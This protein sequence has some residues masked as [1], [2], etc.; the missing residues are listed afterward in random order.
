M[1]GLKRRSPKKNWSK[2]FVDKIETAQ[3]EKRE[4]EVIEEDD[5]AG[6]KNLSIASMFIQDMVESRAINVMKAKVNALKSK[7]TLQTLAPPKQHANWNASWGSQLLCHICGLPGIS[8]TVICQKCDNIAHKQCIEFSLLDKGITRITYATFAG[9][10]CDSCSES[11]QVENDWYTR[12]KKELQ[13]EDRTDTAARRIAKRCLI[14]MERKRLAEKKAAVIKL[15]AAARM[16]VQLKKYLF[17]K[18]AQMRLVTIDVTRFPPP[19]IENGVVVLTLFDTY[20]NIQS[21]RLDK[22]IEE[23]LREKFLIPGLTAN[24]TVVLTLAKEVDLH[25]GSKRYF[26]YAQAELNLRDMRHFDRANTYSLNFVEKIKWPPQEFKGEFRFHM[27]PL[28]LLTSAGGNIASSITNISNISIQTAAAANAMNNPMTMQSG[29]VA[30]VSAFKEAQ[31]AAQLA[32]EAAGFLETTSIENGENNNGD[33]MSEARSVY[34]SVSS[35]RS[36]KSAAAAR[37][38]Q[39]FSHSLSKSMSTESNSGK[40]FSEHDK[41][42]ATA[43]ADTST[44][45]K[46]AVAA[47]RSGAAGRNGGTNSNNDGGNSIIPHG[48]ASQDYAGDS[49]QEEGGNLDD[50][51]VSSDGSLHQQY[52]QQ[53]QEQEQH[54]NAAEGQSVALGPGM[55]V[56]S[57]VT[58]NSQQS[59]EQQSVFRT[60]IT[61]DRQCVLHYHPQNPTSTMVKMVFGPPLDILK[62]AADSTFKGTKAANLANSSLSRNSRYWLCLFQ[63]KL[64]LFQYFGDVSPRF[65]ADVSEATAS[66]V[67]NNKGKKTAVVSILHADAQRQ[68]L[69]EFNSL[70]EASQFVFAVNE[71]RRGLADGWSRF[72]KPADLVIPDTPIYTT[73][74]FTTNTVY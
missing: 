27:I 26:M 20:K 34:S 64:L 70:G 50:L 30:M 40:S 48:I 21:F 66:I 65:I 57:Q 67:I 72:I 16:M 41:H 68:W 47:G 37:V 52:Q 10:Q 42:V 53:E 33:D 22:T 32:L 39:V 35:R 7:P 73:F 60:P 8:D 59:V 49:G 6:L 61:Y 19:T 18:R 3:R 29:M 63:M 69:I 43:A 56:N 12:T 51:S 1:L 13:E 2:I 31:T 24:M 36:T 74:G 45:G 28:S 71:N 46:H 23:A 9:Y 58:Y 25:D 44:H 62:R 14:L 4:N 38:R 5:Y 11:I 55:E 54:F 15:Q 17:W